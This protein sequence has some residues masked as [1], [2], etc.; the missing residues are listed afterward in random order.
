MPGG[1]GRA[2]RGV[3]RARACR[4]RSGRRFGRIGRTP[5]D[6]RTVGAMHGGPQ[7]V[8]DFASQ[9][10]VKRNVGSVPRNQTGRVR[11]AIGKNAK[12]SNGFEG[13]GVGAL[14]EIR[15]SLLK[16]S[17]IRRFSLQF[18]P[19]HKSRGRRSGAFKLRYCAGTRGQPG[20]QRFKSYPRFEPA[21]LSRTESGEKR[22]VLHKNHEGRSQAVRAMRGYGTTA[23]GAKRPFMH[24]HSI[25]VG[26]W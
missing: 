6:L 24:E 10:G 12:N 25:Q 9:R 13:C 11:T 17:G 7:K 3:D 19:R 2:L 23:H 8:W 5:I 16:H 18:G 1:A 15:T 20:N 26:N 21:N 4:A 14:G 22:P